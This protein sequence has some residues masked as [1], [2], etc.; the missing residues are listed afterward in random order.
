MTKT[1][2]VAALEDADPS[3]KCM[4]PRAGEGEKR[5]YRFFGIRLRET[6]DA[7]RV[8]SQ[9]E[10]AAEVIEPDSRRA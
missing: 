5:A 9:M 4:R 2:F 7:R 6:R 8:K 10:E 1:S 3:I